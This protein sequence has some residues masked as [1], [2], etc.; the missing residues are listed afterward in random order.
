MSSVD[1]I[2]NP[3][4]EFSGRYFQRSEDE[5]MDRWTDPQKDI[6]TIIITQKLHKHGV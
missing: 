1:Y 2:P 4:Q 6:I 5:W 3:N